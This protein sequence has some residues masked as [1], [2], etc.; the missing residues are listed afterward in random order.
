MSEITV[1]HPYLVYSPGTN[2]MIP[3]AISS[4]DTVK[5]YYLLIDEGSYEK[6]GEMILQQEMWVCDAVSC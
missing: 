6:V 2:G 1:I 3:G 4:E 5:S